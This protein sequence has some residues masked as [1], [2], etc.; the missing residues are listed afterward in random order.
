MIGTEKFEGESLDYR[1]NWSELPCPECDN[2]PVAV[3]FDYE[4]DEDSALI[5]DERTFDVCWPKKNLA[6]VH[7]DVRS[8][9]EIQGCGLK[10]P[11]CGFEPEN[12]DTLEQTG[13]GVHADQGTYVCSECD[14][15]DWMQGWHI[16]WGDKYE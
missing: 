10:C 1:S 15:E 2:I 3:F 13:K 7:I 6:Y 9:G 12:S 14:Q 16:A 8:E 4:R 5:L 11:A